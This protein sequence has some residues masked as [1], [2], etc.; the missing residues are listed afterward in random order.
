[1][2]SV[3]FPGSVGGDGSTVSD[4]ASATTGLAN[5]GHRTRFVPALAQL[6]AVASNA[7]ANALAAAAS[8]STAINAPGTQATSTSSITP[9][10]GS[11]SLTLAQTGK[12]FAVGQWVSIS[13]TS[14]PSTR[15]LIGAIT[16]FNAGTGAMTVNAALFAGTAGSSW[17]VCQA[18]PVLGNFTLIGA[19]TVVTG[20]SQAAVAGGHY[21]MT[22]AGAAS[23]VTL[24]ASPQSRDVVVVD[25]ATGRTDLVIARNGLPIM[26][27]A[28][29]LTI[30]RADTT[31]TLRYI[32][33]TRGWRFV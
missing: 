11:V 29:D 4:D 3:T 23:T 18:T 9:A 10:V 25:N 17:A 2:A 7:V 5:G 33:G 14:T 6:V 15:W 22:N 31:V 13:D 1:M 8:A 30:D 21:V 27:L 32:D 16:A 20:T 26:S 19:P 24:P 28:E 12:A